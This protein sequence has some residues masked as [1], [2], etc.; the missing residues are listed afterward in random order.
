MTNRSHGGFE[1]VTCRRDSHRVNPLTTLVRSL[2]NER[3]IAN[4]RRAAAA[5]RDNRLVQ[6]L[7]HRL[8]QRQAARKEP[9]AA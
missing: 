3:A 7:A 8:D 2:G 4:A 1:A 6:G 5:T 9:T